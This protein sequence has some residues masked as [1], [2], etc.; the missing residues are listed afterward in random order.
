MMKL[1]RKT[2]SVIA[3]FALCAGVVVAVPS[4]S[5]ATEFAGPAPAVKGATKGGTLYSFEQ[6]DFEH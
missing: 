4:A 6:S 5:A 3:A 2:G 1:G